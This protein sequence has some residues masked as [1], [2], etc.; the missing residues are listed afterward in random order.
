MP[1]DGV[2]SRGENRCVQLGCRDMDAALALA[3]LLFVPD[4]QGLMWFEK[5][6][7]GKACW[8][9]FELKQPDELLLLVTPGTC[10]PKAE[11]IVVAR[12]F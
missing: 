5:I 7:G 2:E 6:D 1:P 4:E 3:M 10:K 8:A 9:A 11:A 12:F